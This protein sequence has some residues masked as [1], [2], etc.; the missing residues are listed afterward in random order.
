MISL[1]KASKGRRTGIGIMSG[2]EKR[3]YW[4]VVLVEVDAGVDQP[5][6]TRKRMVSG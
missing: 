6:E 1:N 3:T 5:E 4:V 2:W